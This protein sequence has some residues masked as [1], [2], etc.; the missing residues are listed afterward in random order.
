MPITL[1]YLVPTIFAQEGTTIE[2]VDLKNF[3]EAEGKIDSVKY[4]L[5]SLE[6]SPLP[7][8]IQFSKDGMIFGTLESNTAKY[9]PYECIFIAKIEKKEYVKIP[10][11]FIVYQRTILSADKEEKLL[12]IYEAFENFWKMYDAEQPLVDIG[13]ILERETTP[14]DIYYLLGRFSTL[15]AWNSD[16]LSSPEN[17]KLIMIEGANEKFSVYDFGS[18]L[19]TVPKSLFDLQR[20]LSDAITASKAIAHEIHRRKWNID[21]AGYDK[22]VSATWVEIQKLNK[23]HPEF[24]AKVPNYDDT[25]LERDQSLVNE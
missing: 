9:K 19:V 20:G 24:Q 23:L 4:S 7:A 17:G 25:P 1:K 18:A 3:I 8:G 21:I 6:S 15:I 5:D 13:S 11:T 12:Q 16:D 10:V 22:M 2:S 14:Q